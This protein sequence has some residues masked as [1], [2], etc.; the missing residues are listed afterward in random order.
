M[1]NIDN[2]LS[3]MMSAVYGKDV[4]QSIH[5]T[6]K[7]INNEVINYN[8]FV[9]EAKNEVAANVEIVRTSASNAKTSENNA[10]TYS[11]N[12]KASET[13][14]KTYSDNAKLSETNAKTSETNAKASEE[15]AG[16]IE[17]EL[18]GVLDD[19]QVQQDR[20]H[21][22]VDEIVNPV[23]PQDVQDAFDYVFGATVED[24]STDESETTENE[25]NVEGGDVNE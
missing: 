3:H 1:A 4:R 9:T 13:N 10:K 15:T 24:T 14:A 21:Q 17:T 6:I 18:Q 25:E 12:A 23:L 5:D 7:E 22:Y 19:I 8:E 11:T 16:R 20:L 2:F